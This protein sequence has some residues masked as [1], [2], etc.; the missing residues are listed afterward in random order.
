LGEGRQIRIWDRN[1]SLGCLVGSNRQFI[2][3]AIPHIGRLLS[4]D[5]EEVVRSAEV[6]VVGTKIDN[7]IQTTLDTL[8][9]DQAVID[10]NSN[11][12]RSINIAGAGDGGQSSPLASPAE[13]AVGAAIS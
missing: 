9:P 1:V 12:Y 10:L 4:A 13:T 2:A 11:H 8:G 3:E 6:V 7:E 5:L